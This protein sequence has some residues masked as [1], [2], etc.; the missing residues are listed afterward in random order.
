MLI[1]I[2]SIIIFII[3]FK[4]YRVAAGTLSLTRL[5]T[6]SYVF[7]YSIIISTFIGSILVANGFGKDHYMLCYVSNKTRLISWGA[8]CYSMIAMPIGMILLN[9]FF[10]VCP[11][12][13]LREYNR[14]HIILTFTNSRL[15]QITVTMCVCSV[16]IFM[17]IK[18]NSSSWPLYQAV[19]EHDYIGASEGRIDVRH[20]F[21]GIIYIK[22]L[23]GIFLV[24]LFSYYCYIVGIC[25]NKIFYKICFSILLVC[26][27]LIL[28]FDTQK[29]PVIFYGI[30][31]IILRVLVKGKV[32]TKTF[33]IFIIIALI[34][35]AVLYASFNSATN[36]ALEILLNPQSAMWGRMFISSYAGVPLS[37][38]WFPDVIHQETWQIGIP[39]FL[40]NAFDMPTT[41]S[42]RLLMLKIDP[43]GN[44][45]S[46][47]FIAEAW[48]NY[49]FLGVLISPL[50]VG[51]NIQSIQIFLFRS[52]KNPLT[53]SFYSLVTIQWVISSGFVNFLYFKAI[54]F[55]FAMYYICKFLINRV[56]INRV[57]I[58]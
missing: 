22:N 23:C 10:K 27:I 43:N 45:V 7:Y 9:N 39:E 30:G 48:A 17:Y 16:L 11:K 56:R 57:R 50:I 33:L 13:E 2:I 31:F 40:L 12:K 19:I 25:K 5:N 53:M 6:V 28:S 4:L 14:K 1:W 32:K 42:A 15:K 29:A 8:I 55:P 41:E 51:I 37:F 54:V 44:L 49:G 20:N 46:S 18:Y 52:Q 26:S 35:M 3:S 34:F 21:K 58:D 47:Y 38:E 24:P 36:G